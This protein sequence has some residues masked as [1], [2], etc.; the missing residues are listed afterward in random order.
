MKVLGA[1]TYL[2]SSTQ[3]PF[4]TASDL[5]FMQFEKR[6]FLIENLLA[7]NLT[8][9]AGP[10]KI[11]KSFLCLSFAKYI[12]KKGKKVYYCSFEDDYFRLHSRLLQLNLLCDDLRIHC[13]RE[14]VLGATSDEE[15]NL[16]QSI[17]HD[18]QVELIILD[19][20]ER[21]LPST[22]QKRDY[23]YYVKVLDTW[24]TL[25]L[26][27]N[28]CI[29]M[30]HHMRKSDG[31]PEYNPN[32][33]ILGSI[34]IPATFDTNLLMTRD[35][36]GGIAVRVEGKDVKENTFQLRKSGVEFSWELTSPADKLGDAQRQ[37]LEIIEQNPG[38]N[39]SD[40]VSKLGKSKSQVSQI[41]SK[42]CG[43]GFLYREGGRLFINTPY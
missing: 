12:I 33:A 5:K 42:L 10:P 23:H 3:Q 21:I 8:L 40:I 14:E 16:L 29:L 30:V 26:Q 28:T 32:N 25:S 27:S 18:E 17:A 38:C 7:R 39:Q 41:V 22:K 34:G 4:I 9:L 19:T 11:G 2:S 35:K 43:E 15:F 31:T 36:D 1:M 20:M 24:A 13:G 37:V 6:E